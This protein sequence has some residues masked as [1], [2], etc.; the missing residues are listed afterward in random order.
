MHNTLAPH[1]TSWIHASSCRLRVQRQHIL[2]ISS[3]QESEPTQPMTSFILYIDSGV[4]F[5]KWKCCQV[6]SKQSWEL[7]RAWVRRVSGPVLSTTYGIC[8]ISSGN[9]KPC[10]L[11]PNFHHRAL[12]CPF[13]ICVTPIACFL[14]VHYMTSLIAD[15][16]PTE[17]SNSRD[18]SHA[19]FLKYIEHAVY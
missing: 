4:Q 3:F 1:H 13:R 15:I 11:K 5:Q 17:C 18:L 19:Q 9:L 12:L 8:H 16:F 6:F 14:R 10:G 2:G 7:M